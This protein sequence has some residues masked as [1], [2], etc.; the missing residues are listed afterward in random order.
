[1]NE[2]FLRIL[3]MSINASAIAVIVL[4]IRLLLRRTPRI[5]SYALWSVVFFRLL[6]PVS[7]TAWFSPLP[8]RTQIPAD[9]ALRTTPAP[10]TSLP[11]LNGA[12][13]S[14]VDSNIAAQHTSMNP[15][16][17]WLWLA[18]R[19]WIVVAAGLLLWAAVS[20]VRLARRLHTATRGGEAYFES[21]RIRSP[22]VLGF[23]RPRIYVPLGLSG[24]TLACVL[25]HER[26]H[27][28]RR[29]QL[30]KPVAFLA[31]ALHWMNPLAWL[32]YALLCRDIELSCD[33]A[34][35]RGEPDDRRA[36]YSGALLALAAPRHAL[37]SPLAFG[38]SNIKARI[39]NVLRWR[40]PHRMVAA[41][42]LVLVAVT[43]V[44][45]AA[46]P[47]D[48]T[49]DPSPGE[50]P[51]ASVTASDGSALLCLRAPDSESDGW[52]TLRASHQP[53]FWNDV[54]YYPLNS[55]FR[56]EL[57]GEQPVSAV[58][59]DALLLSENGTVKYRNG[60]G[61]PLLD[62]SDVSIADGTLMIPLLSV[63]YTALSSS[64]L[65]YEPGRTLRGF[66][67]LCDF[68]DGRQTAYWFLTRTDA[69][70]FPPTDEA[71]EN[72]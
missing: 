31:L 44:V 45:C 27:I 41:V 2:L 30:V 35:L 57:D 19:L 32:C 21:D 8:T 67:V 59:Y 60:T 39:R 71:P 15:S 43:A 42:A 26:V 22:F 37:L 68:A 69:D 49:A 17:L 38:E 1:M 25:A 13:Q 11:L 36:A 63:S 20:Y 70:P 51:T 53:D 61:G 7:F 14:V 4:L 34:V 46:D 47:P 10:P 9:I 66:K 58:L 18:A 64:S 54:P 48:I 52:Q 29:D 24:D 5:Y 50:F 72:P 40:R 23:L 16:Q 65:D 28:R 62:S 12:V 56:F 33:E 55:E 3:N 6:C